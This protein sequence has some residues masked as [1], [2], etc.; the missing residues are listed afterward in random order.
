MTRTR[1]LHGLHLAHSIPGRLRVKYHK[2][3]THPPFAQEL[4]R[5]LTS[6][7]GVQKADVNS[8]TGSV[9]V[10]Y[11]SSLTHSMEFLRPLVAAFEL[12]T[13]E[14]DPTE[15]EEWFEVLE[16]TS[17]GEEF[18]SALRKFSEDLGRGG[19]KSTVPALLFFMGIRSLLLSESLAVPKWYE[20]F[21]FAFGT[22]F[23]LNTTDQPAPQGAAETERH[24]R[25]RD[26][27]IPQRGAARAS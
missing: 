19:M 7:A 17:A 26:Q 12:A 27:M 21:W 6:I 14:I 8:T 20:F 1:H 9:V 10:H 11:E 4:H 13:G 16:A 25:S 15:I 3:R 18:T 5:K 24:F 23:I 22:Y 2:V